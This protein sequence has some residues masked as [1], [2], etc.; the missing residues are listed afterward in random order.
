VSVKQL[1]GVRLTSVLHEFLAVWSLFVAL[2]SVFIYF[3]SIKFPEKQK[4]KMTSVCHIL[5]SIEAFYDSL[6]LYFCRKAR[7]L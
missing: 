4:F 7:S 5:F 2:F 3:G 1:S 6:V